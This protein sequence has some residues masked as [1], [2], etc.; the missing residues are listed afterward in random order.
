MVGVKGLTKPD[1]LNQFIDRLAEFLSLPHAIAIGVVLLLG[2]VFIKRGKKQTFFSQGGKRIFFYALSI[3]ASI[4]TIYL[5]SKNPIW[6]YHF[7]GV[8]V[9]L[10]L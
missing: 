3:L 2:I 5:T 6:A 4:F 10:C 8:D 1:I 9:L 7:I